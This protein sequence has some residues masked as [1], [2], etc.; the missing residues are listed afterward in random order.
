VPAVGGALHHFVTTF[1]QGMIAVRISA[2]VHDD[3]LGV[4][5]LNGELDAYTGNE[6]REVMNTLMANGAAYLLVDL[7]AL[8]YLDSVGLGI[9]IGGAKH[10]GQYGGDIAVAC[11]KESLRRIF[12]VSGTSALLNV[13]Q[14]VDEAMG[15]LALKRSQASD[16]QCPAGDDS[17]GECSGAGTDAEAT[18]GQ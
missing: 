13:R 9:M 6:F 16:S 2:G 5:K 14:T 8:E 17:C 7:T 11:A 4:I 12:D 3:W 15:L 18:G 1:L 10:T